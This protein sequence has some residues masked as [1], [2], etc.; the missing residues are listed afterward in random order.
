[1]LPFSN[2]QGQ[3]EITNSFTPMILKWTLPSLNLDTP[4]AANRGFSQ[5]INKSVAN[6]V[7]PDE[8]ARFEPSHLDLHCLQK[9]LYWTA[10]MKKLIRFLTK[11][12]PL[13]F[14]DNKYREI[15]SQWQIHIKALPQKQITNILS[16]VL[17]NPG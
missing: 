11:Y 2:V 10:G 6:S 8:M 12:N 7:D 9:H 13:G 4:I 5:I 3:I 17:L 1:M 15:T 16:I 14:V